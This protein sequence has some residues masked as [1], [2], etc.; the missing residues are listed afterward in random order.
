MEY[1]SPLDNVFSF[2][3]GLPQGHDKPVKHAL[4]NALALF[5]LFICCAGAYALYVILGPFIKPLM[6]ALLVGSVLHPFKCSL[7][8]RFRSW[9]V[10]MEESRTPVFIGVFIVPINILNDVSEFVGSK[11][12]KY[13]KYIVAVAITIPLLH[14]IYHYTP[15]I[16]ICITWKLASYSHALISFIIN[17]ATITSVRISNYLLS[18]L[19]I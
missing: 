7:A 17:N 1:R 2:I 14:V 10:A 8:K 15:R 5:S 11:S 13:L 6:W 19:T 12:L 3:S 9:F 16:F 18:T 4:Y